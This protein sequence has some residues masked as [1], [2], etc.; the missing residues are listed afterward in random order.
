MSAI[1]I[2]AVSYYNT[3][4]FIYGIRHSQY[5]SNFTLSLDVPSVCAQK[6]LNNEADLGLI[7]VGSF[8]DFPNL[9]IV[10]DL[11][12]GAEKEVKSVVLLSN[13]SIHSLRTIYLDTDSRTSVNLARILAQKYWKINPEFKSNKS[14]DINQLTELDGQV[15]IGD[16]TFGQANRF[17]Y[18]YDLAADW[19]SLTHLP[20]VFASWVSVRPLPDEF[21]LNFNKALLWGINHLEDSIKEAENLQI[22]ETELLSYLQNDISYPLTD[23]KKKGMELYLKNL[24]LL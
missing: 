18:C 4:P 8:T 24:K 13:T 20:F 23:Q 10:S 17:K 3:L 12:I 5:L 19:I 2:T 22:S 11:C 15:L 14:L 7:P 9:H 21:V 6:L 16:K 1:R